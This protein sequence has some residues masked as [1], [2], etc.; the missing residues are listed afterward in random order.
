[1]QDSYQII[2]D[3]CKKSIK[4]YENQFQM[5][6]RNKQIEE[7]NLFKLI[8]LQFCIIAK[9]DLESI[10][11]LIKNNHYYSPQLILRS[12][13]EYFCTLAY[14]EQNPEENIAQYIAYSMKNK[15]TLF[16]ALINNKDLI[17]DPRFEKTYKDIMNDPL[18]EKAYKDI[19]KMKGN[20]YCN[21]LISNWPRQI[22]VR[23]KKAGI[24]GIYL[25]LYRT[26]S[27]LVHP[28][29]WNFQ[30][31]FD[32]SKEGKF[33]LKNQK[34]SINRTLPTALGMTNVMLSKMNMHFKLPDKKE[35]DIIHEKI[36]KL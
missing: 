14:L 16:N 19:M 20:E 1:M 17:N 7:K 24:R 2:Y 33:S 36:N 18:F 9:Q 32:E 12:L 8:L 10:Y 28:D 4:F 27:I 3:L 6:F 22:E 23:A 25:T 5:I 35:Y 34:E 21:E 29:G 26:L 13:F 30:D 11:L 15:E 31:F